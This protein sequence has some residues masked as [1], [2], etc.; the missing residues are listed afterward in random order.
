MLFSPVGGNSLVRATSG[1]HRFSNLLN[2]LRFDDKATRTERHARDLFALVRDVWNSFHDNLAK[3]NVASQNITVDEQLV[4]PR[5]RCSF[6]QNI[7]TK[8]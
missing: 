8:A 3:Y 2:H 1:M 6:Y 5:G 7:P 4:P